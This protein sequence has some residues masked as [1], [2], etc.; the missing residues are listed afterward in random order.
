MTKMTGS[1]R[2]PSLDRNGKTIRL[3]D[4]AH[5]T[6]YS[7]ATVSKVLNGHPD[8]ADETRKRI[9]EEL[10]ATG[11]IKRN[12][13]SSHHNRYI[14]VVFES[15]DAIW[16]M[17]LLRG[18]ISTSTPMN[19]SVIV[20]QS[21]TRKHVD[22]QWIDGVIERKPLGVIL[23]FSD[24]TDIERKRLKSHDIPYVILDPAGE[25]SPDSLSVQTDNWTGGLI[26]TRHL[27]NLGHTRIGIITGPQYMLC[28]KARLDGYS[29]ALKE[30][31]IAFDPSLMREGNF[32]TDGGY[33][34]A[35]ELLQDP[36]HR[37]SA[38]FGGSDLQCMGV[39]EAARQLGLRIPE[40]L[41]VVGFD[42]IQTSEFMGPPLT[43][44]HQPLQDMAAAATHVIMDIHDNRPTL[45]T[46]ILP[47]S[48]KVRNSTQILHACHG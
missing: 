31:G 32:K 46:T 7:L 12:R 36:D 25:P 47:V 41:S 13:R 45:R 14:E 33:D 9:D 38:I 18:I 40:D 15:L 28:S 21:G 39:Y 19:V 17:E 22:P 16:A 4:I 10:Q 43:T 20:A 48:L 11:Y 5:K 35:I 37:P 27:L 2:P 29:S 30:R 8:V 1:Y 42:D 44:V 34:M 6:G 24:L 26:A 23:V 3:A